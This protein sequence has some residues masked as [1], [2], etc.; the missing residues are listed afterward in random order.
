M[1]H[2]TIWLLKGIGLVFGINH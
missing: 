1:T 2:K